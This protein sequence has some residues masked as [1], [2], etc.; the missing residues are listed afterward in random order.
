MFA[1]GSDTSSDDEPDQ[2][3]RMRRDRRKPTKGG[4]GLVEQVWEYARDV[5]GSSRDSVVRRFNDSVDDYDFDARHRERFNREEREWEEREE[6]EEARR[7]E[8]M[9]RRI[10]E[11]ER[12]IEEEEKRRREVEEEKRRRKD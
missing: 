3:T 7:K 5:R 4:N 10:Q 8:E 12:R 9:E 2:E 11:T 6:R 1:R